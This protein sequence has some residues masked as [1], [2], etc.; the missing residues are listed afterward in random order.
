[1]SNFLP[2][3]EKK[4]VLPLKEMQKTANVKIN[5]RLCND[6]EE[7]GKHGIASHKV[8]YYASTSLHSL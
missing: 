4:A 3:L 6:N 8:I 5:V 1:M 2:V 7:R